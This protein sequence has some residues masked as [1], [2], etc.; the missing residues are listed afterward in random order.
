MKCKVCGVV[1]YEV[2]YRAVYSEAMIYACQNP[3]CSFLGV[4]RLPFLSLTNTPKDRPDEEP[5]HAE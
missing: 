2:P 3:N 1:M 4:P 5:P